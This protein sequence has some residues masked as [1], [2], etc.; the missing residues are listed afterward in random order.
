MPTIESVLDPGERVLFHHHDRVP[1][2]RTALF[3]GGAVVL[4]ALA[5]LFIFFS[6]SRIFWLVGL[7]L[8]LFFVQ[9]AVIAILFRRSIAVTDRRL[10]VDMGPTAWLWSHSRP[11]SIA[12]SD[13]ISF[14][15]EGSDWRRSLAVRLE[16]GQKVSLWGSF[17]MNELKR[18][19]AQVIEPET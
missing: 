3:V 4:L 13:V 1:K 16:G 18:A 12:L 19:L 9:L 6:G 11:Y 17:D 8:A 14:A 7:V 10:L 15:D 2:R 5:V